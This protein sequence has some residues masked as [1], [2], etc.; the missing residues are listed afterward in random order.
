MIPN[1]GKK[2]YKKKL[3]KIAISKY[4][5]AFLSFA[6]GSKSKIPLLTPT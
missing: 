5:I 4:R 6:K 2:A 3:V 1:R